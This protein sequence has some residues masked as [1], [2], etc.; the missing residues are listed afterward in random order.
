MEVMFDPV[1]DSDGN[2]Y[3]R[4]AL[5]EWLKENRTSPISRQPLNGRMVI[6]NIALRGAIHDFMGTTWVAEQQQKNGATE[7]PETCAATSP[8]PDAFHKLAASPMRAK[9]DSYLG[10][11]A[12]ELCNADLR[13]NEEGCCAFRHDNITIVLDVPDDV[14]IFCFYTRD[15]IPQNIEESMR[16]TVH[17]RALESNF[18]QVDT[19]GG[20]LAIRKH[21]SGRKEL[22]FSYTDRVREVTSKD[23][24]NILRSFIE[25][26]LTLRDRLTHP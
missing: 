6:P 10:H 26:T 25:T 5:L 2:T 1:L 15:L 8:S 11:A 23:F 17:Q 21:D 13:L 16:R 7:A 9:V 3:E 24:T 14:G 20:C 19:R 22:V 12:Q 4:G 18:L